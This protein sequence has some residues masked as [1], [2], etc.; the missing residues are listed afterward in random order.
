M[1]TVPKDGKK[2]TYVIHDHEP[3]RDDTL[4]LNKQ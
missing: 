4:V 1:E 3:D 2:M